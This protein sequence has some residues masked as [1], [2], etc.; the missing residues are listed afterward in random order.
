MKRIEVAKVLLDTEEKYTDKKE[1]KTKLKA[2]KVASQQ[3]HTPGL[4]NWW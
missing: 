1:K 4:M 2:T 3:T